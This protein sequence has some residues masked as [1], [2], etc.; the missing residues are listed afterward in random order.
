MRTC[1]VCNEEMHEGYLNEETGDTY[2]SASCL[3]QALIGMSQV[4]EAMDEDE[5]DESHI[6]WTAWDEEDEEPCHQ[7]GY[8]KACINCDPENYI[9]VPEKLAGY[10]VEGHRG[11][12]YSIATQPYKLDGVMKQLFLMEHETYG[13]EANCVIID[14]DGNLIMASVANGFDDLDY[15][16]SEGINPIEY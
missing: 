6:F 15:C 11:T 16:L 7:C 4:I 14:A 8:A 9:E 1:T 12:W 13:D 10:K 3:D 2:C 5:L